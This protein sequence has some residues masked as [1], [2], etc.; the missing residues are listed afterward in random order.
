MS[1]K[2]FL[3]LSGGTGGHVIPA[4]NFGNFIIERGYECFLCVDER[5]MKYANSFKGKIK[6]IKSSHLSYNFF[7]KILA[8][9][10]LF[11]GFVQSF[12]YLSK[13]RPNTCI[14]FGSYAT[15]TPLLALV[16][17]R[18]FV[19]TK[20]FLHEQNSI[21][22]KVNN[23]F[24]PFANKIFL[25]FDKTLKLKNSFLKKTFHVGFPNNK[26]NQFQNRKTDIDTKKYIKLCI[27]G[28]SQGSISL[29]KIIVDLL[30]KF[31]RK[32]LERIHVSIQC[33]ESQK[34]EIKKSFDK[35][36]IKYDL[37]YFFDNFHEKLYESEVLI[38]RA[39]AG[40]INGI[41]L[42]QIP[43]ILVPLPS[44]SNNH[45]Y[46]NADYLKQR[47][48]ALLIEQKDLKSKQSLFSIISL[49]DNI[50]QQINL[51]KNLQQIKSF[52]TNQLILN[53]LNENI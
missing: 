41:I 47:K 23:L 13:I 32:T 40:T 7:G 53:H 11:I 25:N 1:K 37:R 3:I 17:F 51:I 29:N 52:D 21:M 20:I 18:F 9:I 19:F 27:F 4:V 43:S 36:L 46:N 6:V 33:P 35:L 14:S 48:A 34:E 39:G 42:T 15:F 30:I 2:I 38:G 24:T 50:E 12:I 22:G 8:L 5:G 44:S 31:P 45:Q 28:G 10:S 26:N 49:I 16:I